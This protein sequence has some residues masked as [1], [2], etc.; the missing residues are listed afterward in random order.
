[1]RHADDS[2]VHQVERDGE[3]GCVIHRLLG[4]TAVLAAHVDGIAANGPG[5]GDPASLDGARVALDRIVK[6]AREARRLQSGEPRAYSRLG[7][8]Q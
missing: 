2:E 4:A 7:T 8:R 6:L 1:M 5:C 3:L